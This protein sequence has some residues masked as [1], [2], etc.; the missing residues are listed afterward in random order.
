[1]KI[2]VK[3]WYAIEAIIDEMYADQ[4]KALTE[5]L[6][7]LEISNKI[8]TLENSISD[9]KDILEE[10]KTEYGYPNVTNLKYISKY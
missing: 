10:W 7:P 9:L 5:N 1:M 2:D 8:L 4:K 6:K 3:H